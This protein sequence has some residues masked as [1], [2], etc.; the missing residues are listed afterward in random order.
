MRQKMPKDRRKRRKERL[1]KKMICEKCKTKKATLFYA[2]DGGERHALCASCGD[3]LNKIGELC[4]KAAPLPTKY[5]PER[6]LFSFCESHASL[7]PYIKHKVGGEAVCSACG[8]ALEKMIDKGRFSCPTCYKC[9]EQYL[10]L[11]YRYEKDANISRMPSSIRADIDKQKALE[12]L[13]ADIRAAVEKENYELAA[14]LR[15]KVKKLECS[16]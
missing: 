11:P 14:S 10:A 8:G 16:V 5:V 2:D 7:I 4:E 13:K 15:D 9:F 1:G 12:A 3:S 6:T